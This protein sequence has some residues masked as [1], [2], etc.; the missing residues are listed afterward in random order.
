VISYTRALS[1]N[2]SS[3]AEGPVLD[4]SRPAGTAPPA[5]RWRIGAS[6]TPADATLAANCNITPVAAAIL[7]HR[8]LCTGHEI[9]DF[10]N[11]PA[12]L[13]H[14]PMLL[15]DIEPAIARL[16]R[17]I[18]TGEP[19][20]VFGDYDVDGITSTAFLVHSLRALGAAVE[21]AIPERSD[22]YGL[23]VS[24]VEKA[25]AGGVGLIITADCGIAAHKS[26]ERAREL[27]LDLIITD[28]HEP[29]PNTP[30]P[31]ATAVVNPKRLDSEYGFRELCGCA[32]AFKVMQGLLQRHW[33]HQSE[34]FWNDC[35]ELVGLASIADCVP[36]IDENRFL[37]REGM[38]CLANTEGYGLNAL[39]RSSGTKIN[40][41]TEGDESVG[42]QCVSFRLAPRL[43]AAGRVASPRVALEL[44]LSRDKQKCSEFASELEELNRLRVERTLQVVGEAIAIVEQEVDLRRDA[45]LIVANEGW[46]HGLIGLVASRLV[47]RYGRPAIVLGI[48]GG[49]AR[50]SGR[51]VDGFDLGG[52]LLATR[53][54]LSSGGGHSMACGLSLRLQA[55]PEF[56][57]RALDH[58]GQLLKVEDLAPL[59]EA[60]CEVTGRDITPQLLRDLARF[61]PCGMGNPEA[62]LALTA[63]C[64]IDSRAIGSEG[65]HL[66]WRIQ[67]DGQ[68]FDAVWFYPD[69]SADQFG[70]G[71]I[72]DV[73][74]TP[75]FNTFQG[76]PSIQLIVKDARA[77]QVIN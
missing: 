54:L 46:E 39:I 28:H 32:V 31:D 6:P 25:S 19:L 35:I 4:Y 52:V 50:G 20:L 8:G 44:L 68:L 49:V 10:L 59:V 22:G 57:E 18:T 30:L 51:S 60:D 42:G 23:S 12:D 40:I 41:D 62:V 1:T 34:R 61:E 55:L 70:I 17:A 56:H 63:V 71:Q 74:F 53:S 67:A 11:P 27:G 29:L 33:P 3:P 65:Q 16:H 24:A 76:R 21:Y 77:S 7:R 64:I 14:D 36:L 48:E 72:V 43:N 13:L 73:C 26:A 2:A 38:R 5:A 47:E 58:A 15:P 37:A 9:E 66:S 69:E 45:I 75:Q